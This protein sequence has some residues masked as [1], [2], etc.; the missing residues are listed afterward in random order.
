LEGAKPGDVWSKRRQG[1]KKEQERMQV[2]K[3][4]GKDGAWGKGRKGGETKKEIFREGG[5]PKKKHCTLGK[6]ERKFDER[7]T[8]H[9]GVSKV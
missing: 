8:W 6:T 7:E 4:G 1:G 2:I 9:W 3:P 5:G